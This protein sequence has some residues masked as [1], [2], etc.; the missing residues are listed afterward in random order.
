MIQLAKRVEKKSGF[1][2]R[3]IQKG[4]VRGV[5][6]LLARLKR[7]NGEFDPLL[8]TVDSIE[9][10]SK[11]A[12]EQAMSSDNSV[13]LVAEK[14]RKV[15]GMVKADVV[16]RVFYEPRKEGAIVEFYILP[17]FRRG[18]LGRELLFAVSERLKKKGAEL[19]TAEFPSQN[20]IAGRFYSK[21]GFRS[22]TNVYARA[23]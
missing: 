1:V 12:I 2:I 21:L 13:V 8:K 18:T 10:E 5:A 6:E 20:E 11:K 16:D 4:D 19:I 17:E 14:Q 3:T 23:E 7:L 15:A 22:L 9:A